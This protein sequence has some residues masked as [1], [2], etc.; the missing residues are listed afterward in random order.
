[1]LD[2]HAPGVNINNLGALQV[3]VIINYF[4]LIIWQSIK[5]LR[6]TLSADSRESNILA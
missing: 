1:M 2:G 6:Y 5:N 4:V 3:S